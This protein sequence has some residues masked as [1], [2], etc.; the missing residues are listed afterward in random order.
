MKS[1]YKY[2]LPMDEDDFTI[3]LP[4][5]AEVLTI[6]IQGETPCLWALVDP[7]AKQESRSFHIAGTGHP[8]HSPAN[9]WEWKFIDTFQLRGGGLVFHVFEGVK[10]G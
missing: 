3:F 6:Q 1:V 7:Y 5:G 9:G 4:K 2:P 8:I 10:N